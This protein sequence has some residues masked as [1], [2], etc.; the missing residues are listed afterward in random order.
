ML[1]LIAGRP[2]SCGDTGGIRSLTEQTEPGSEGKCRLWCSLADTA[3]LS[4]I[5][6]SDKFR[7]DSFFSVKLFILLTFGVGCFSGSC[8]LI[9]A[10]ESRGMEI[11]PPYKLSAF[12]ACGSKF[13]FLRKSAVTRV[14]QL[15]LYCRGLIYSKT[16]CCSR[17]TSASFMDFSFF[18]FFWD[19]I[20]FK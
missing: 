2:I 3:P 20:L 9:E 7:M 5:L 11:W 14:Q 19:F 15:Q 1:S 6:M 17:A 13:L 8:S 10:R 16:T 12:S 18:V 4:E